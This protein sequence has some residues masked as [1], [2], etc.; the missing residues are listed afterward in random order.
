RPSISTRPSLASSRPAITRS[1]VDLPQPDGPTSTRNSPSPISSETRSTATTSPPNTLLTLSRRISATAVTLDLYRHRARNSMALTTCETGSIVEAR[2]PHEREAEDHQAE[3]RQAAGAGADRAARRGH[4]DSLRASAERGSRRVAAHDPRGP[5][6]SRARGLPRAA[7]RQRHLCAAA[8]D[9]AAADDDVVQRGHAPARDDARQPHPLADAAARGRAARA[10]PQRVAERADRRREAAPAGG[11]R[12][13]GDRDAPHPG[14]GRAGA[15]GEG[16]RRLVLRAAAYEVRHRD[17]ERHADDR[18][19]GDE[20]GGVGR[21]RRAAALTGVPVR[22]DEP[23]RDGAYARVRALDLPRRSLPHRHR[24]DE[25]L[26]DR[27][28]CGPSSHRPLTE[29]VLC[30]TVLPWPTGIDQ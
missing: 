16:P 2:R 4:R 12:L 23:R 26:A 20:R 25:R 6:R 9:L 30:G 19:D 22:A 3:P 7:S 18:A 17:R 5:R 27:G 14:V 21:A 10:L 11:R 13:D 8:E 1:S 28:R 15:G 24:A 29:V